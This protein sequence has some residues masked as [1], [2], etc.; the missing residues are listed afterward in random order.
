MGFQHIQSCCLL[1]QPSSISGLLLR[2][3]SKWNFDQSGIEQPWP[4]AAI[5]RG[6]RHCTI[7]DRFSGAPEGTMRGQTS[8]LHS[9]LPSRFHPS[10][11]T[12]HDFSISAKCLLPTISVGCV[13]SAPFYMLQ[14]YRKALLLLMSLT[15]QAG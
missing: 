15:L 5:R 8:S 10:I 9:D 6:M 7:S 3:S 14:Y 11:W 2:A 1:R 13:G 4:S 12:L